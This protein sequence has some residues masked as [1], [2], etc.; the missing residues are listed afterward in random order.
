[1]RVPRVGAATIQGW[2]LVKE[3]R[4]HLTMA[5]VRL[6]VAAAVLS[7]KTFTS[8][9]VKISLTKTIFE[10]ESTAAHDLI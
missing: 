6:V 9:E 10:F 2:D 5:F 1:M 4:Y 8:K 3:I 7:T